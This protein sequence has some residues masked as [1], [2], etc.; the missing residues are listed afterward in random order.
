MSLFDLPPNAFV[1]KTFWIKILTPEA[2][3]KMQ[4][5][6]SWEEIKEIKASELCC[7]YAL[8]YFFQL[9]NFHNLLLLH[10]LS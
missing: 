9:L 8:V 3:T 4:W 10:K 7:S 2:G 5:N 1:N 6:M